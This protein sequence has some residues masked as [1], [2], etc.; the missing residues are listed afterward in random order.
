MHSHRLAW[1]RPLTKVS[2]GSRVTSRSIAVTSNPIAASADIAVTISIKSSHLR[3]LSMRN[4]ITLAVVLTLGLVSNATIAQSPTGLPLHDPPA[5]AM[6]IDLG[7]PFHARSP[8]QLVV[9]YGAP[10][11]DYGGNV[12]PGA[13]TLCL[14]RDPQ[15]PCHSE[16][17]FPPLRTT[18]S[19][20]TNAWEPH[21]LRIAKLVYPRGKHAAPFL[22]IVTGSLNAGDGDQILATQLI[23]YDADR[24]AFRRVYSKSTGQNN[25]Q[26]VR[27]V[28]DGL[29]RGSV[30]A[31]EPQEHSPYG[32]WITV[33]RLLPEGTYHEV[34]RYRSATH[35]GDGNRLAVIDSEMPNIYRRLGLWKR[36]EPI[37]TPDGKSCKRPALKHSE[38]WCE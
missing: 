22:L 4:G 11:E 1:K 13:L 3:V 7:K 12:A 6:Q 20:Y 16:Q 17:V 10:V 38:L 5:Q 37:P 9:K 31:A 36:G 21:Y 34:L 26:E 23:C 29:L 27:F 24:D 19:D 30:I 33:N 8:W 28:P 14:Q 25:N 15:G 32:Y 2:F 18:T 35:Y